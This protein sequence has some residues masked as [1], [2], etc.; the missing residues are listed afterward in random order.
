MKNIILKISR[1]TSK[2]SGSIGTD[3]IPKNVQNLK[4][5][6]SKKNIFFLAISIFVMISL[7]LGLSAC[8]NAN[9]H[10]G[11]SNVS[12]RWEYKITDINIWS[13]SDGSYSESIALFNELGK[14]GWEFVGFSSIGNGY[15][16]GQ[17]FK[18]RLP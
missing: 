17:V 2:Q 10:G 4:N 18:R 7:G 8:D 1:A 16:N 15:S 11:N 5:L 13:G 3:T 6:I 12:V 9:A 14:D